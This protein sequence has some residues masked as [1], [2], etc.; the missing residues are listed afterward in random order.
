MPDSATSDVPSDERVGAALGTLPSTAAAVLL[1][2]GCGVLRVSQGAVDSDERR[3]TIQP[4]GPERAGFCGSYGGI[5][6]VI[7]RGIVSFEC[8]RL[9]RGIV[10]FECPRLVRG[11]VTFECP[12]AC[13]RIV[14]FESLRLARG[15]VT[16]LA[17]YRYTQR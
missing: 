13:P 8:P 10:T 7:E 15:I 5:L 2:R 9:V 4:T 12:L 3:S 14:T 16:L 6:Q 11:I 1:R 17:T